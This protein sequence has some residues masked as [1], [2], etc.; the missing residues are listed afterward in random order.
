VET[1]K[2]Q[3]VGIGEAPGTWNIRMLS[4]NEVEM[5]VPADRVTVQSGVL[6]VGKPVDVI[7]A[8]S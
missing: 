1:E 4:S 2:G 8:S 7:K 6:F 3:I 5:S